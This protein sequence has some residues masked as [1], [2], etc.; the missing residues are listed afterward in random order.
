MR[1][2]TNVLVECPALIASVKIGV[3]DV[4][5]PLQERGQCNVR[6]VQTRSIKAMHIKWCDVLITVRGAE[7]ATLEVV[8][9][10]KKYQRFIV[11]YLDD[12]LLHVPVANEEERWY[13]KRIVDQYLIPILN[14]SDCLWGVNANIKERYLSFCPSGR[15][16]ENK[17]PV[18]SLME[19]HHRDQKQTVDVLFAGSSG[20]QGLLRE[21][22]SPVIREVADELGDKVMFTFI[23]ADSGIYDKENV[24]NIAYFEEYERYRNFVESKQFDIGLA[25]IKD[26]AFYH[27]KY[28]NKFLEYTSL[29]C[30][31]IYT[32]VEPYT[33][34]VKNGQNGYLCANTFL[35]W[36]SAIYRAI[37]DTE[38]RKNCIIDAQ[39][40]VKENHNIEKI[41]SKLTEDIP[42]LLSYR[43]PKIRD[44]KLYFFNTQY[45]YI[46]DRIKQI[47]SEYGL[48]KGIG[49]I[50]VKAVKK[51]KRNRK[52]KE[53]SDLI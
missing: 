37:L 34:V 2:L 6:F 11:Y 1:T 13:Y 44:I 30:V 35:D 53:P 14:L 28:Y 18:H 43:G 51:V 32:D 27:C 22:L 8:Q 40:Y 26:E 15:W 38:E 4:L 50:F 10:A 7:K 3:L 36:K 46:A 45:A 24:K 29:G 49:I 33:F 12:D 48:K 23:G 9:I 39:E 16:I 19:S 5:F 47:V 17:V 20:H 21:L 42:E 25:I 52:R 41:L 31:G